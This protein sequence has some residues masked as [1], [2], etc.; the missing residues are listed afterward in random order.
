VPRGGSPSEFSPVSTLKLTKT[1]GTDVVAV[2]VWLVP[3]RF[4]SEFGSALIVVWLAPARP[5]NGPRMAIRPNAKGTTKARDGEGC[6]LSVF[7]G[8]Y[9]L[10][11]RRGRPGDP[12][13]QDAAPANGVVMR[14]FAALRGWPCYMEEALSARK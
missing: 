6:A 10:F 3:T 8:L 11:V 1:P 7:I 13:T 9:L 5:P 4:V 14:R 12:S 2:T